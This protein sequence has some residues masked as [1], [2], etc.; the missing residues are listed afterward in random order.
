MLAVALQGDRRTHMP[1]ASLTQDSLWDSR[2][3]N[4]KV[5]SQSSSLTGD[6]LS[7]QSQQL[8]CFEGNPSPASVSGPP[9]CPAPG[10][11]PG[12]GGSPWLSRKRSQT[13][14]KNNSKPTGRQSQDARKENVSSF[15]SGTRGYFMV[16]VC[17]FVCVCLKL[18]TQL[19]WE[20]GGRATLCSQ[21]NCD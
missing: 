14:N 19:P 4:S 11:G 16:C 5:P 20:P 3:R 21:R 18:L 6:H 9:P 15:T 13:I 17:E 12:L 7:T 8:R 1:F 2:L 10:F